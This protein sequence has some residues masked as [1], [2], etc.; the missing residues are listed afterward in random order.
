VLLLDEPTVGV[1]P[2]SRVRLL[3]MVREL[4]A[5]GA[6]VLYTTH[7]M[8]EAESLCDRLAIIDHGKLI[9]MGT[10]SELRE[11]TGGQDLLRLSGR[12]PESVG[13]ALSVVNNRLAADNDA[14]MFVT[15]FAGVFD[16]TTGT[17]LCA[18][19]GHDAPVLIPGD[20][21]ATRF[22]DIEG[23][24]LI[25][26]LPEVECPTNELTLAPDDAI[27]ISTDGVFEA[28]DIEDE[29]FSEERLLEVVAGKKGR[30]A[31]EV[32]D[33]LLA[34]VKRFA[35]EAEQSDDITIMTLRYKG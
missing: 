6:C 31:A 2:Q 9:V 10:L 12:F 32:T 11:R 26:L 16:P 23:G 1:D 33:E 35:G 18:S 21:S 8:D 25:G 17:L 19:G 29:F 5:G 14:G 20:G 28:R 7:Y 13:A 22:L 15:V 30:P 34:D 3:D 24:P 4:A 27:I